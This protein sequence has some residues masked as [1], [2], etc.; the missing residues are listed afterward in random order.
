MSF[1]KEA[2]T[3]LEK[4]ILEQLKEHRDG[5][6]S[7]EMNRLNEGTDGLLRT[8]VVNKMLAANTIEM[9]KGPT[10]ALLLR[11]KRG[12]KLE[13]ASSEEQLVCISVHVVEYM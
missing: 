4:R 6:N 7:E 10:G 11:L 3:G 13:Q 1:D 5:L 8:H 9:L 2:E 12:V